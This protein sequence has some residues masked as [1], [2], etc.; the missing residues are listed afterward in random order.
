SVSA[1]DSNL[2]QVRIKFLYNQKTVAQT[3]GLINSAILV[4]AAKDV[5]DYRILIGWSALVLL[6]F[7][8]RLKLVKSFNA[9]IAR[10]QKPFD[11]VVW[12]RKFV[13]GTFFSGAMWGLGAAI[14]VS[15]GSIRHDA[16]MGFIL[17]G[18]TAGA[19]VAYCTSVRT[20]LAFL[21]PS[22]AP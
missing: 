15:H 13:I 19:T 4:I 10:S 1:N 18:T 7:A 5:V 6:V 17:A 11:P 14:L 16:F 2:E 21:I 20:I 9:E 12:E 22:L 3:T 8:F